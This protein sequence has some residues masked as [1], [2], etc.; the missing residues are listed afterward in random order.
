VGKPGGKSLL[1]KPRRRWVDN[2]KME[3]REIGWGGMGWT[4]LPQNMDQWRALVNTVTSLRVPQNAEKFLSSCTTS[5][6]SRRVHL[7][8][9]T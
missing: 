8:E 7:L 2:V 3:L 5:R 1:R 4:D 6:Y 9:V